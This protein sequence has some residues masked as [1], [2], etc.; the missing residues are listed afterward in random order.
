MKIWVNSDKPSTIQLL[1]FVLIVC[2][3]R[4]VY[5]YVKVFV[6]IIDRE[7]RIL[8]PSKSQLSRIY[9]KLNDEIKW[10]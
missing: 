1:M 8:K 2:S 4:N 10:K 5:P 3:K 6:F 7:L 9:I